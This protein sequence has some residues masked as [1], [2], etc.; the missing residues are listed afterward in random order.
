MVRRSIS[1]RVRCSRSIPMS[2]GYRDL[3]NPIDAMATHGDSVFAAGDFD[4]DRRPRPPLARQARRDHGQGTALERAR[5]ERAGPARM[6]SSPCTAGGCTSAA[7]SA[8]SA[9]ARGAAS[10]PSTPARA[11]PRRWRA[12]ANGRV[13]ALA[14]EGHTLYVAGDFTRLGGHRRRHV[15]AIDLRN[16]R[17]TAWR[18]NPDGRVRALAFAGRSVYLGGD[19]RRVGGRRRT[20]LAAV[21]ASGG[22][23]QPWRADA[24]GP[25]HALAVLD[26][27]VYAGGDFSSICRR[28]AATYRRGRRPHR[29]GHR[30]EPGNE[31]AR[32]R[33]ARH[34]RRPR[35]R[36]LVHLARRH[37]PD[38]PRHLPARSAI[39]RICQRPPASVSGARRT[40]CASGSSADASLA[41]SPEGGGATAFHADS[42]RPV[43]DRRPGRAISGP[44]P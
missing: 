39:T 14:I 11:A 1:T 25:V 23:V 35:R 19:F 13:R 28:A 24:N 32:V 10:P 42:P 9:D 40:R 7:T 38:R 5:R 37:Q 8:A 17:V 16:G 34:T 3:T 31:R 2:G 43:I 12:D 15:A 27:T 44:R 4:R 21:N 30:L 33:A 22:K 41:L 6:R 29:R 26:G 36:G 20:N 18:P